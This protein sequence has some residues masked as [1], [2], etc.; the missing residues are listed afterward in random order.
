MAAASAGEK[1]E[2]LEAAL[3]PT[4]VEYCELVRRH[5]AGGATSRFAS[6]QLLRLAC[7]LDLSDAAA[8]RAA[9]SLAEEL[10]QQGPAAGMFGAGGRGDWERTLVSFAVTAVGAAAAD[11][12][13]A[14]AASICD[15]TSG[16]DAAWVQALGIVVPLLESAASLSAAGGS[17]ALRT[18]RE[19]LV[20]PAVQHA[21]AA[22]RR[23]GVRALGLLC[24]LEPPSASAIA[25]LRGAAACDARPVRTHATRALCDL[26]LLHGPEKLDEA[27]PPA[28][29]GAVDEAQVVSSAP[30]IPALLL[31]LQE[32]AEGLAAPLAGA[33][34]DE[35]ELRTVAAEGIAK[36]LLLD[37]VGAAGADDTLTAKALAHLL[38]LHL[39]AD[40][41][42][43]PRLAQCL[44]VFL[45]TYAA[46]SVAH[47]QL[48]ARAA[49]LAL[50]MAASRKWLP[51]LGACIA[52]LMNAE[53]RGADAPADMGA[54]QLAQ[55]LLREALYVHHT[56]G[57]V[58][59][60]KAYLATLTRT[61]AALTVRAPETLALDGMGA[62]AK[63]A[64]AV[65]NVL[66]LAQLAHG[67]LSLEKTL[68][69]ELDSCIGR[70]AALPGVP[71]APPLSE[72]RQV[73]LLAVVLQASEQLGGALPFAPPVATAYTPAG[74]RPARASKTTAQA[75][76]R[77]AAA[78]DDC[79]G[80]TLRVRRA[81]AAAAP[82]A[83]SDS[84]SDASD[85]E[86]DDSD[87]EETSDVD[88]PPPRAPLQ[89]QS[90]RAAVARAVLADNVVR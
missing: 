24:M 57:R 65:H 47:K 6:R 59:A 28:A 87:E 42:A 69:K 54:E 84:D 37:A 50:R 41:H 15:G 9:S 43:H 8:S 23:E 53:T 14:A 76:L 3:P 64:A 10:L 20:L 49:P 18:L 4:M 83:D 45:P 72:E 46:A 22:V 85:E 55:D 73:E 39:D 36:L 82:A 63:Q 30:L 40:E 1:L 86:D 80:G 26:A 34:E 71:Q 31:G 74:R 60:T 88:A 67:R 51:R 29:A 7:K 70:L 62:V 52:T 25:L 17:S 81:T 77:A 58:A 44:T 66:A 38:V 56:Y 35:E 78:A 61:A 90:G 2:A 75:K 79:A 12:V 13:Y 16:A 33:A 68:M 48:L 5:T 27:L 19:D 32:P 21:S 11:T 89:K